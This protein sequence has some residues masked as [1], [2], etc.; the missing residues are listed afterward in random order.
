[1]IL[2]NLEPRNVFRYFEEI[3]AIPHG[4][5]HTDKIADYVVN[6]AKV[7]C[8]EYSRD[9]HNNVISL[10]RA[11]RPIIKATAPL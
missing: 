7:H 4:S 1:M 6:F 9:A 8:L 3:C 2:D 10:E 5:Y 11:L